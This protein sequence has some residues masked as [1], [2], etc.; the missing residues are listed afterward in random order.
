MRTVPALGIIAFAALGAWL[1]VKPPVSAP[2]S[3]VLAGAPASLGANV[4]MPLPERLNRPT[5][6]LAD[7]DPFIRALRPPVAAPA[8]VVVAA[9]PA[10][11]LAAARPPEALALNLRFAGRVTE[12]DGAKRVYASL[13]ETL[14]VL[15]PGQ[16]LPNGFQVDTIEPNAVLLRHAGTGATAR[17]DLPPPPAFEIR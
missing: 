9:P 17:L 13:G 12:P 14:L 11:P 10:Q 6:E 16:T 2:A 5:L 7:K 3:K 4:A 8:N 15:A 1:A